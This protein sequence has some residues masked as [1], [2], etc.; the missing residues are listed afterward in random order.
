MEAL[1]RPH[2]WYGRALV[3]E[4]GSGRLHGLA[5][6]TGGG[7]AGN[8]VRVLPEGVRARIRAGSWPRPGLFRWLIEAGEVPEEDARASFNL[9]IGMVV[10]CSRAAAPGLIEDLARAG[11]QVHRIG[12]VVPG[13]RGV[14]WIEER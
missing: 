6:I 8:L 11:E 3:S 1:L 2:R 9:G 5:H 4:L 7:I 12:E 10:V 13:E 14:E